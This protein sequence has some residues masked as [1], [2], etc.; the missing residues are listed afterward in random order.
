[1]TGGEWIERASRRLKQA[2]CPDPEADARFLVLE[3]LGISVSGLG[4]AVPEGMA[5]ELEARLERV[6]GAVEG[7]GRVRVMIREEA[8]QTAMPAFAPAE[9]FTPGGV[10]VVAEGAD[11]LTVCF[12]LS[13]AVQ[14]LLGVDPARI[15][16]IKMQED[17]P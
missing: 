11:D 16:I 7:A 13:R 6:L 9:A 12:A 8:P 17:S 2:G 3:T 15:E 1:M 4:R 5:A 10:V 14:A